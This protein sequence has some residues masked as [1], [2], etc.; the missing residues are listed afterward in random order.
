MLH[1]IKYQ[2]NARFVY[3]GTVTKREIL[4]PCYLNTTVIAWFKKKALVN[5]NSIISRFPY[6]TSTN[7]VNYRYVTTI[8]NTP[9]L[10]KRVS[11]I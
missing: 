7:V 5:Q 6:F 10:K 3:T 9:P 4:Q 2:Y 1:I 8:L 11:N